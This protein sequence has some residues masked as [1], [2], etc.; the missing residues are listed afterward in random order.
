MIALWRD[1]RAVFDQLRPAIY[2]PTFC[3]RCESYRDWS[4]KR[5][6]LICRCGGR[7][8]YIGADIERTP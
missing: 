5:R 7:L 2:A 8:T 3:D 4:S 1:V 6:P